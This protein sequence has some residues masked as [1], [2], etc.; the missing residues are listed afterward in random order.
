MAAD[1]AERELIRR[2]RGGDAAAFENIVLLHQDR[3]YNTL[4]G[5]VG[6]AGTAADLTQECLIR[7]WQTLAEFD[8]RAKLSTWL[9]R[10]AKNAATDHH[11][12]RTAQKRGGQSGASSLDAEGALDPSAD[13][14]IAS[15]GGSGPVE[16]LESNETQARIRREIASLDPEYREVV[17]LR[18]LEGLS[19]EDIADVLGVNVGTVRSRLFRGREKLKEALKDLI[20]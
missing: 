8:D 16:A 15:R 4:L 17:V 12:R 2:A 19:Y 11:R 5:W 20:A 10:V 1:E 14:R 3:L 9:Y 13:A 7:V 18:E 6:D